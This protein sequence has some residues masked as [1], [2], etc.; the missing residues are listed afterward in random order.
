MEHHTCEALW[1]LPEQ[2]EVQIPGTLR[3]DATGLE[4][5]L[6]GSFG[7]PERVSD[8]VVKTE[9][10]EEVLPLLHGRSTDGRS[11]TLIHAQ[12]T[13]LTLPIGQVENFYLV[14]LE[15]AGTHC[16]ADA[17]EELRCEFDCLTAWVRPP[18]LAEFEAPFERLSVR[19]QDT[20]LTRAQ[21]D[22]TEIRLIASV[23]GSTSTNAVS[24]E[25]AASFVVR[26]QPA[27]DMKTL[28]SKWVRSLHDLLTLAL[29]RSVHLTSLDVRA[30]DSTEPGKVSFEPVQRGES[31][32]PTW[33]TLVS[34]TSPTVFTL[35]NSPI[36]FDRLIPQWFSLREDSRETIS[37]L[38]APHYAPFI[39]SEHRYASLFQAAESVAT[40]EFGGREKEPSEHKARVEAVT[41]ALQNTELDQATRDWAIH[42]VRGRNDKSLQQ[43]IEELVR[44]LGAVGEAI[45]REAPDFVRT[46]ADARAG[47]SHPRTRKPLTAIQRHWHGETLGWLVRSYILRQLGWDL[48][49][50]E[51]RVLEREPFRRAL[52]EIHEVP[53]GSCS[54]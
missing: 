2:P 7:Q 42:V 34:N 5:V 43:K 40:I 39:F 46:V 48:A 47:V 29:G 30:I 32:T 54:S 36:P 13:T 11:I 10:K 8:S 1:W 35:F 51:K 18:P 23:R 44:S 53:H 41:Q 20:E 37:L 52:R 28:L 19:F 14:D 21:V 3:F 4:L 25:Q 24:V 16:K 31:S 12:G 22:D 15:I 6:R 27:I 38:L 26:I 33:G 50:V 49:V 45:V 9:P 17:F